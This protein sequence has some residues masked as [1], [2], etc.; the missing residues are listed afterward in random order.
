MS[1]C[2][3]LQQAP[4]W[5]GLSFLDSDSDHTS[6]FMPM[7]WALGARGR[8]GREAT[9]TLQGKLRL[10]CGAGLGVCVDILNLSWMFL[11]KWLFRKHPKLTGFGIC[12]P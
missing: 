2:A 12:C 8:R 11:T 7:P 5:C 3:K 6:T 10:A 1:A 9:D 4:P